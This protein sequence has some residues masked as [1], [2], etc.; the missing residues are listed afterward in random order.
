MIFFV[1]IINLFITFIN[2]YLAVKI[3]QLR[4]I[5]VKKTRILIRCEQRIHSVLSSAPQCI[6]Q[7]QKNIDHLYNRYQ[8]L[9]LQ[10]QK[11]HKLIAVVSLIYRFSPYRRSLR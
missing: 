11:T 2:I 1:V 9:Q 6:L 7:G 4:Q 8:T 10:V 5:L 3:L